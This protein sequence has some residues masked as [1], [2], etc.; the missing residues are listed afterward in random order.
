MVVII[1]SGCFTVVVSFMPLSGRSSR[2]HQVRMADVTLILVAIVLAAPQAS[3]LPLIG[4]EVQGR[5]IVD[6][7]RR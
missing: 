7:E 5:D 2:W 6:I 1:T 3:W 4:G